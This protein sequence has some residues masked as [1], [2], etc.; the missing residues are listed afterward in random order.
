MADNLNENTHHPDILEQGGVNVPQGYNPD[1]TD[2]DGDGLV[3]DGTQWERPVDGFNPNATDGDG[4]GF[5]QD[6][7]KWERPV[8]AA[9]E[10]EV[11]VEET[12]VEPVV[13]VEEATPEPVAAEPVVEEAA[14]VKPA[15]RN[16]SKKVA[17]TD[18]IATE[19]PEG[20]VVLLSKLVFESNEQNSNS[21][22]ALQT[23]LFELGYITAGDD[24]QGW[25]SLGTVEALEDYVKDSSIEADSIYS[26]EV[27]ESLFIGTP[28]QVLP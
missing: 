5:V 26:K 3:Q 23:R 19:L 15:K 2:G 1:A 24:K 28:V 22:R 14:V 21:V 4:D 13:V 25:I 18:I 9:A 17:A 8:T 16:K 10:P 7:T 12:P 11:V 20:T 6:G 27:I